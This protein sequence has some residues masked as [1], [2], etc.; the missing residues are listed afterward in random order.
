VTKIGWSL[1]GTAEKWAGSRVLTFNRP[2]S[3]ARSE[4]VP[5]SLADRIARLPEGK[6]D[7]IERLVDEMLAGP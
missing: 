4:G 5:G 7:V 1:Q 6:R 3:P 2:A